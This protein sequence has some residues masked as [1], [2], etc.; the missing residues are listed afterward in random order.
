SRIIWFTAMRC[1]FMAT[2]IWVKKSAVIVHSTS[3]E[4]DG[5]KWCPR[6]HPKLLHLDDR[7][8][9]VPHVHLDREGNRDLCAALLHRLPSEVGL[10]SHMDEQVVTPEPECAGVAALIFGEQ[11]QGRGDAERRKDVRRDLQP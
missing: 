4:S 8:D 6:C 11:V 5:S 1:R 10:P 9:A 7:R 2:R 3:T